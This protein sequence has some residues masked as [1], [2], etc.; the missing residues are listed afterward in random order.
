MNIMALSHHRSLN[1]PVVKQP[2]DSSILDSGYGDCARAITFA[3]TSIR[4]R[5]MTA[6]DRIQGISSGDILLSYFD[7]TPLYALLLWDV[8]HSLALDDKI[9]FHVSDKAADLL[10]RTYYRDSFREEVLERGCGAVRVFVKTAPLSAEQERGLNEW[11]FCIPTG[12]DIIALNTCVSR[13]LELNVPR[14]EIILCGDPGEGFKFKDQVSIVGE[15]IPASPIHITRKKNVLAKAARYPNL[16]IL[17][18]RVLLPENFMQSVQRFGDD[19]PFTAFPSYWFADRWFAVPRRYSDFCAVKQVAECLR[20]DKR[21]D[22]NSLPEFESMDF[23]TQHPCRASFGQD[24]LTGSLYLCK[25]SVWQHLPQNEAL[26]W[27]D[28][29]DVEHGIRAALAGIPSRINSYTLTRSLTYR[30]VFHMFGVTRG[31]TAG[32]DIHLERAP[33]E[34]WG[35]AAKALLKYQ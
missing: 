6:L 17:H 23:F 16:C 4:S 33:M 20:S 19:Y 24:Y 25:R 35:G 28:Y 15:D 29:E 2:F 9:Y 27:N 12:G 30:S 5:R 7:H 32:G 21:P 14:Y 18:D 31:V 8:T 3:K 26:Y 11:S 22:R 1:Q 34:W 13:I 10:I